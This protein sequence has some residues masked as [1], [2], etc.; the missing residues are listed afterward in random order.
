MNL[1]ALWFLWRAHIAAWRGG[2]AAPPAPPTP[3]H[4]TTRLPRLSL[5]RASSA[6]HSTLAAAIDAYE[7]DTTPLAGVGGGFGGDSNVKSSDEE[8]GGGGGGAGA[9]EGAAGGAHEADDTR[10]LLEVA[11]FLRPLPSSRAATPRHL[12]RSASFGVACQ[13]TR[14]SS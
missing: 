5:F 11:G 1:V 6:R 9:G 14:G 4:P 10:M 13:I 3:S 7:S 2:A 12:E 8:Q